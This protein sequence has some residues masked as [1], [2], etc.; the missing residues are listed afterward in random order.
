MSRAPIVST[1]LSVREAPLEDVPRVAGV[2]EVPERP[3][4]RVPEQDVVRG[5]VERQRAELLGH[6]LVQVHRSLELGARA[7]GGQY[8]IVPAVH[9]WVGEGAA[10]LPQPAVLQGGD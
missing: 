6:A 8:R 4:D 2:R 5:I 3:S 10:V 1:N 9:L 7:G